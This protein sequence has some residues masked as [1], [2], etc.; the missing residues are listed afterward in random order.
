[1]AT[2][3]QKIAQHN[4]YENLLSYIDNHLG[5]YLSQESLSEIFFVS[6]YHIAHIFKNNLGLPLHQYI[7]KKRLTMFRDALLNGANITQT[8]HL[9]GFND[10]SSF[11]RA[12]KKEYRV[13]P[14][15]YREVYMVS[16]ENQL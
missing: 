14:K 5:E 16:V 7:L 12:F 4:L 11:F 1:M 6:K 2:P 9:Y 8:F 3:K 13:S 10:Y 15:E